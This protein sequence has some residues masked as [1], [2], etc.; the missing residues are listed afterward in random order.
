[1]N[2]AVLQKI[3]E[4]ETIQIRVLEFHRAG[5]AWLIASSASNAVSFLIGDHSKPEAH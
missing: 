2:A 4:E 1:M 3:I 5:A